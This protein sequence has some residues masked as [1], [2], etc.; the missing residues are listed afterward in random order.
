MVLCQPWQLMGW[1]GVIG[2]GT[3]VL[4]GLG[5]TCGTLEGLG[6]GLALGEE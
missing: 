1:A 2:T 4:E 5:V 6:V 3:R